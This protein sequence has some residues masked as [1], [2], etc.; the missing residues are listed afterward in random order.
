MRVTT[1]GTG[2]TLPTN[3]VKSRSPFCR[4]TNEKI[5]APIAEF[6]GN[7]ERAHRRMRTQ[8]EDLQPDAGDG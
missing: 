6:L 2:H 4:F 8:V 7:S 3:A 5:V 1:T